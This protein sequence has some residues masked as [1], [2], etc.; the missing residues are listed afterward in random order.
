[1]LLL[2]LLL[3]LCKRLYLLRRLC[4][5]L[6]VH[7]CVL[8]CEEAVRDRTKNNTFDKNVGAFWVSSKDNC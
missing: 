5:G 6:G 1:M 7:G 8:R 4:K 3:L 2:L